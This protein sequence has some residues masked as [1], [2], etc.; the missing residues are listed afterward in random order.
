MGTVNKELADRI[1]AGE[2]PEDNVV[3]IVRYDNA[4]GGEGYG[5]IFKGQDLNRY[6]QSEFVRNPTVYWEA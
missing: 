4:W 6:R 1:I 2:F 5:V 3:K